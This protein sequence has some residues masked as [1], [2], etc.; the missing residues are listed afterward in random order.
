MIVM[1]DNYDSFTYNLVQY[2]RQLGA[3][4]NV[5]RNDAITIPELVRMAPAG[6]VISPGPG[7]PEQAGISVESLD[8]SEAF[9]RIDRLL[10]VSR[11]EK[12]GETLTG[13]PESQARGI[14][15]FLKKHGF[16]E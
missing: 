8:L 4:V 3:E 14:I 15:T 7:R 12:R 2:L 6:I 16:L 11:V 9:G 13:S 1:I 5:F 10:T